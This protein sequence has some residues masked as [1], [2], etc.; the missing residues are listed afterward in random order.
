MN[1]ARGRSFKMQKLLRNT[2]YYEIRSRYYRQEQ[3]HTLFQKQ[4]HRIQ[5]P[6]QPF[7]DPFSLHPQLNCPSKRFTFFVFMLYNLVYGIPITLLYLAY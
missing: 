3:V 7:Y 6:P 2:C 1:T 5:K 4:L